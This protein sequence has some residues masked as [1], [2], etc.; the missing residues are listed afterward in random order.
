[1]LTRAQNRMPSP[2]SALFSW[3]LA[4][5][6]AAGLSATFAATAFAAEDTDHSTPRG[7]YND[8]TRKLKEGKLPEAESYLQSAVATQ[9]EKIQPPALYNLGHAHFQQGVKALKDGP[10]AGA[11]HDTANHA[12][13]SG[14][15]ALH[16]IDEALA[17]DDVREMVSAY[18]R[19]RGARKELKSAI[20]AVQ[21]AMD[22]F[23]GVLSKWRRASGDFRSSHELRPTDTDG[24]KNADVVDRLIAKL[25]DLEMAMMPALSAM[26]DKREEL[27]RK[28]QALKKKAG[29]GMDQKSTGAGEDDDDDDQS[30]KGPQQGDQDEGGPKKEGR[31]M[32]LSPEDA[33]RLL[34]MLRLDANRKLIL[35]G[36]NETGKPIIRKGR[37]W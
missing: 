26:Q 34:G 32:P 28:M 14:D 31:E 1:M 20:G 21:R 5:L 8:G 37:D 33:E 16:A 22:S 29:G 23:G 36:T 17:Q 13:G 4:A 2:V 9:D 15:D 18:M 7:L 11:V 25:V 10:S 30:P 19:G 3:G 6:I 27:R 35:G 12:L 24:L